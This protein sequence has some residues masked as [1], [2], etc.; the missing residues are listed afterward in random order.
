MTDSST[1]SAGN[2][3]GLANKWLLLVM[4]QIGIFMCTFDSG[5]VNLALPVIR[6][7]FG[8]SLDTI[9][10]VA[11]AYTATAALALPTAAY[12]GRRFGVVRVYIIGQMLFTIGS[13][14]CGLAEDLTLLILLRVMAALGA[15]IILALD[16]VIMLAAFPRRLHGRALGLSGSTFAVGILVGLAAGGILIHLWGWRSIFL[17]NLPF[18]IIMIAL[19]L[20]QLRAKDLGLQKLE[21]ISFDWKGLAWAGAALGLLVFTVSNLLGQGAFEPWTNLALVVATV[22][23]IHR[24]L[25]HEL[26]STESFLNL[27]L[28]KT[29]PLAYNFSN[30]FTIRVVMGSVNFIIPFYLQYTLD[31]SPFQAGLALSTGAIAMGLLGPFAGGWSDRYGMQQISRIGITAMAVALC[32]YAFLPPVVTAESFAFV[33][34]A[35][36]VGQFISGSGSV[37]FSAANTNSCLHSVQP[38]RWGTVSSLQSVTLMA[39]TALGSTLAADLVSVWGLQGQDASQGALGEGFPPNALMLLFGAGGLSLVL[40]SA[41]GWTRKNLSPAAS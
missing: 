39:G 3:D 32:A 15:S 12:L 14:A 22:F 38:N 5:V 26:G 16:K 18:G 28:L 36:I 1:Q 35:L 9:K 6:E 10:W 2:H 31:L 19:G 27:H 29:A 8:T 30:A 34:G 25:A 40:L 17:I 20:R 33:L 4:G 23:A 11:V 24:W 13:V 41:I 37:F 21:R 7:E